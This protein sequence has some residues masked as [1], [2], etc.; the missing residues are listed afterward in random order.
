MGKD[1]QYLLFESRADFIA[2]IAVQNALIEK[3]A[4]K[5]IKSKTARGYEKANMCLREAVETKLYLQAQFKNK[6]K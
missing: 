4:K 6:G 5:V 3:Y 1:I 2:S